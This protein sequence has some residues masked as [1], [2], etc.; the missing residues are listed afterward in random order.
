[1]IALIHHPEG[2]KRLGELLVDNLLQREWL[3]F[4]AA[5]AFVKQS[6]TK[7]L[8]GPL[9]S[10][11][12]HGAVRMSV[13]IDHRG[14]SAEGLR[15]LLDSLGKKGEAFVFHNPPRW[16]FHPKL[17]LFS[18][19]SAAEC[20]IGSGNL[21]EGGLFT[22]YEA[23]VHLKLNKSRPDDLRFLAAVESLLDEWCD[24]SQT[25]VQRLT[26]DII[27]D[28]QN[29]GALPSEKEIREI[30]ARNTANLKSKAASEVEKLFRT[31]RVK[32]APRVPG[33]KKVGGGSSLV[34]TERGRSLKPRV[35]VITLQQ[36]D[37]GV[38][39]TTKGTSKRSPE[40][41]IPMIA[42]RANPEFWGWPDTF[43]PDPK[44]TKKK[45]R[46]GRGKI[47]RPTVKMLLDSNVLNVHWWYNPDKIDIRLRNSTLRKA[48]SV[49]DIL[50]IDKVHRRRG[51]YEYAI[52]IITPSDID[53]KQHL[54]QCSTPVKNS[55]KRYG[56]F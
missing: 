53:F 20:F 2:S 47:D 49:G 15:D 4:R 46:D 18:N 28:L 21:T 16:T 24:S 38:G 25:T 14:T 5:V 9:Q 39:Q 6:G 29:A 52:R 43:E 44:W 34:P 11:L 27:S 19:D 35:F 51:D 30:E 45:D 33:R 36:T 8:A 54:E 7:H 12:E 41:F 23:F 10:F 32:P 31:V 13:G 17:Y 56:Y 48:G 50:R 37:V 22:N 3:L 1:M 42:V 26:L 40:L 55:K